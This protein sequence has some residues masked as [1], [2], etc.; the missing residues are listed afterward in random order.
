MAGEVTRVTA[1]AR[2]EGGGQTA[3]S[4]VSVL[5]V[6]VIIK[7]ESALVHV[8]LLEKRVRNYVMMESLVSTV[9]RL[10]PCVTQ[11]Q[12]GVIQCLANVTVPRE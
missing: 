3:A 10:V 9:L 2:M 7:L 6:L 4:S 1:S 5:E 12:L 11:L 8:D